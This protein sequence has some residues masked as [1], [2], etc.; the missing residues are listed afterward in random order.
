MPD[1]RGMQE[2]NTAR[3]PP[4]HG[5]P[6]TSVANEITKAAAAMRKALQNPSP[7]HAN[8]LKEKMLSAVINNL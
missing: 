1:T 5:L 8:V 7:A 3:F 4:K 2:T 6:E